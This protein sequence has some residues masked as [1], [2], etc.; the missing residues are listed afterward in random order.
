M[1]GPTLDDR[2]TAA[3]VGSVST[4]AAGAADE[5][6]LAEL[7][8]A[9]RRPALQAAGLDGSAL[10]Q[11]VELQRRGQQLSYAAAHP[12]ADEQVILVDG[13]PVG[14]LVTAVTGDVLEVLDLAVVPER[15]GGG[16]GRAVLA[17]CQA[18]VAAAGSGRVRLA[19]AVG[20]P[21]ARLYARLGFVVCATSPTDRVMEWRP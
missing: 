12:D 5:R 4:R 19:V 3:A 21:A 7:F 16:V 2:R 1:S 17:A 13:Q 8:G 14:R 18:R 11:L 10:E 20:N 6:F 15:Q 9:V